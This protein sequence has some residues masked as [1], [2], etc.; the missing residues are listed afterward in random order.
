MIERVTPSDYGIY[1][2][3][4]RNDLGSTTENIR[5]DVTSP[6][7]PPKNLSI[8]NATHDSITLT[9]MPGFDGGKK[10]SYRVRYREVA[11]EHYNYQDA[12]S[13]SN[14]MTIQGLKM[15]SLYLFSIM[16][17]N[18]LGNSKYLPDLTR[19]QTKGK[20]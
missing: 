14:K 6:P 18:E 9:W 17:A 5:L 13:N 10:A 7:D 11:S 3:V 4:S 12:K 2:C 8:V 16:A 1:E 19:A 15:N 20:F